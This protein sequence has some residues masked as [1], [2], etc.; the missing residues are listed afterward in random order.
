VKG[1][2]TRESYEK[3]FDSYRARDRFPGEA[4][5]EWIRESLG[6]LLP[7]DI[8][9]EIGS[10]T[11]ERSNYIESLGYIV[12]R[13]DVVDAFL[14]HLRLE[15]PILRPMF[16]DLREDSPP[17]VSCFFASAVLLHF[18]HQETPALIE[19][20]RRGLLTNGRL[21][22]TWKKRKKTREEEVISDGIASRYFSYW[23]EEELRY[24][25]SSWRLV[26]IQESEGQFD[27]WFQVVA[28]S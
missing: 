21:I 12:Q 17:S 13:S 5:R 6:G 25:F 19:K 3:G 2:R 1:S 11:G 16:F 8:I 23:S 9:F 10:G 20:L 7:H 4:E 22:A 14:A 26:D 15:K 18:T 24:L 28:F 27:S